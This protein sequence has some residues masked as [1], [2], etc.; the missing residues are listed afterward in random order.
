MP[1]S[2]RSLSAV[3]AVLLL[4]GG[5]AS[6]ASRRVGQSSFNVE[7]PPDREQQPPDTS[8]DASPERREYIPAHPLSPLIPP[9]YPEPAL[10]AH[11]GDCILYVIMT[12]DETGRVTQLEPNWSRVRLAHPHGD[13]F[14]EAV[15][16]AVGQW[17]L[18]PG[19]WV[20]YR[21][22]ASGEDEYQWSEPV[23]ETFE[24]RFNFDST[25]VSP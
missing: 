8:A 13:L 21:R 22:S 18:S 24:V 23:A 17:R 12:V 7:L 20:H 1:P 25:T 11:A 9:A 16:T 2:C 15:R 6:A 3:L 10:R 19:H 4:L 5:C 14:L